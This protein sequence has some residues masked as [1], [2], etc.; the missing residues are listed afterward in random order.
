MRPPVVIPL[1]PVANGTPRLLKRLERVL[2]DT[3]FFETAKETFD[4][5]ILFRRVRA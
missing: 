4:D 5:A 3:L 1:D 2:P